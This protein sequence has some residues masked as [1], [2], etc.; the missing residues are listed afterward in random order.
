[1]LDQKLNFHLHISNTIKKAIE[2]QVGYNKDFFP[3]HGDVRRKPY[4]SFMSHI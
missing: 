2:K 1:M 4:S 3:H